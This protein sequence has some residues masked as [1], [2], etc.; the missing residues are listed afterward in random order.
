MVDDFKFYPHT[1]KIFR[2]ETLDATTGAPVPNE[3]YAGDCY[4]QQ[5]NTTLKGEWYQ[6]EDMVMLDKSDV[7]IMKGDSIEVT[8]ENGSVYKA[9]VKQAYPVEDNDFG[10]QN[11]KLCQGDAAE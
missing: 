7:V 4:L 1:C 2:G 6:G 9:N 3:I 8:L 5:G 10:G 11:L